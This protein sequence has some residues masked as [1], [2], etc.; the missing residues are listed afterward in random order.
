MRDQHKAPSST[1]NLQH[2]VKGNAANALRDPASQQLRTAAAKQGN[3]AHQAATSGSDSKRDEILHWIAHRLAQAQVLQQRE[4]DQIAKQ[5][6]WYD[7]VAHKKGNFALPDPTR[8]K[9][10]ANLYQQAIQQLCAGHLGRGAQLLDQAVEAERAVYHSLPAQV[11]RDDQHQAP[12]GAPDARMG[13]S[14]GASCGTTHAHEMTDLARH[15]SAVTEHAGDV[16]QPQRNRPHTWW[17]E[18]KAEPEHKKPAAKKKPAAAAH[19]EHHTPAKKAAK[20]VP[21]VE[22]RHKAAAKAA[23]HAEAPHKEAPHKAVAKAAPQKAAPHKDAPHKDAAHKDAHHSDEH[24]NAAKASTKKDAHGEHHE[25]TPAHPAHD[26]HAK[27]HQEHQGEHKQKEETVRR[28]TAR[29]PLRR[30]VEKHSPHG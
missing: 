20:A 9:H 8:W 14:S 11:K 17:S 15:L 22:A 23:P 29:L 2:V 21:H 12:L 19:E 30:P 25:A 7:E 10:C 1:D 27:D 13:I 28:I 4:L 26:V 18:S 3:G 16:A 24:K 6:V 5:R